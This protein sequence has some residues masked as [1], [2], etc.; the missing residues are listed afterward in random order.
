MVLEV[1]G[2]DN[3][4]RWMDWDIDSLTICLISSD[5]FDV[6]APLLSVDSDDLSGLLDSSD[7]FD[8]VSLSNWD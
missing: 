7:D 1:E 8:L 6:D 4:V 3:T 5:F 2:S